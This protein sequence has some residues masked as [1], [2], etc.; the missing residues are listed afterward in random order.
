MGMATSTKEHIGVI[1]AIIVMVMVVF[2]N[3]LWRDAKG[4]TRTLEAAGYQQIEILPYRYFTHCGRGGPFVAHF[5]ATAANGKPVSG[6]V[7]RM[8]FGASSIRVDEE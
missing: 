5:T 3:P 4:A 7:C 8:M 6:K 1:V 2:N